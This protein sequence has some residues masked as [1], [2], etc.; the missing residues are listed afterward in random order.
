MLYVTDAAC[1]TDCSCRSR[2]VDCARRRHTSV[3]SFAGVNVAADY[4]VLDLSEN[5]I[6]SLNNRS[7][8]NAPFKTVYLSNNGLND[9][10]ISVG[11]FDGLKDSVTHLDLS[12]NNIRHLPTALKELSKIEDLDVS[13][14]PMRY[15]ND[16]KDEVMKALGDTITSFTFGSSQLLSWPTTLNHFVQLQSLHVAEMGRFIKVLPPESF[17]GFETTLLYLKMEN[18]KLVAVPLG[19]SRLRNLQELHFDDNPQVTDRGILIQSFPI[20]SQKLRT[21]SLNGDGLTKFPP[22]LKY[23]R[24]LKNLS[25]DRNILDFLSDASISGNVTVSNLSL[26]DCGLDR[27]PGALAD[28]DYLNR[29]D[30][31]QNAIRTIEQNDLRNLPYLQHLK[32]QNSSLEYISKT[33]FENFNNLASLNFE[34]TKLTQVPEAV[35]LLHPCVTSLD[36]SGTKLDCMCETLVWLNNKTE[37]CRRSGRAMQI[38][39]ECDTII[40]SVENYVKTY[41]PRCPQ[42][43]EEH[44]IAPYNGR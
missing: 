38:K 19:I 11:A 8:A 9:S 35:N 4:D 1:P 21:V 25:L 20:R 12:H 41:I 16:F 6:T 2:Y 7:F 32:I 39:G 5:S 3:P 13:H 36:L 44:N 29:L 34:N 15:T 40:S 26:I 33:A 37:E 28:L 24:A 42:Y 30:L 22:V 27:I 14:N 10:G 43:K 23:L 31:S 18:T 17:H